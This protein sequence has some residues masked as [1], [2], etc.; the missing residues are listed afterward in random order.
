MNLSSLPHRWPAILNTDKQ[1]Y[2]KSSLYSAE[3]D[4]II[5]SATVTMS[6]EP[7]YDYD[8]R[9]MDTFNCV[10]KI[11][12]HDCG[13]APIVST[14]YYHLVEYSKAIVDTIASDLNL[15]VKEIVRIKANTIFQENEFKP[16]FFNVPHKDYP[17][18]DI[19]SVVYYVDTVDGDT[20]VFN[21]YDKDNRTLG[22]PLR[23]RPI[24]GSAVAFKS[25]VYHSSSNPITHRR[26]T[27][28]NIAF[29]YEENE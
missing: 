29:R 8:P 18:D 6:F 17:D 19:M 4:W 28:I 13:E 23:Y 10:H 3:T 12:H 24:Q 14:P 25:N 2:I 26:R 20:V 15:N 16:E 27:V 9:V 1:D 5:A 11:Y 7:E 22:E 21:D